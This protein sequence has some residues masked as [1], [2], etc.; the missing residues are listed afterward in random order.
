MWI[1]MSR[2]SRREQVRCNVVDSHRRY[3]EDPE[4]PNW[5]SPRRSAEAP[6]TRPYDSG[7]HDRPSLSFRLPEAREDDPVTSTG[8]HNLA[9]ADSGVLRVPVRG[10]EYPPVRERPFSAPPAPSGPASAPP[11]RAPEPVD[12]SLNEPTSMVPLA[13]RQDSVYNAR[14][15]V[16]SVLFAIVT[17]V[18]LVPAVLLLVQAT[19]VDDPTARGIVPAVLLVLGLPLTGTGLYS[20]AAGGRVSSRDAWLRP[21]VTY[22]PV[23]VALLIAAGLAVA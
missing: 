17:V 11:S 3:A 1:T 23:G 20:L 18:L 19:F 9:P 6:G 13:G 7:V 15:P 5:Y 12:D 10:P 16:S 4:Q 22:L 8:S 21:P 14:R 2:G